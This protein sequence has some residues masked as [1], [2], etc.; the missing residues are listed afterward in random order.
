MIIDD[1]I[2]KRSSCKIIDAKTSVKYVVVYIMGYLE[3]LERIEG[4]LN[5]DMVS[6][7]GSAFLLFKW[8]V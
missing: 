8:R 7:T 6:F 2:K 3:R 5:A 4:I 1:S